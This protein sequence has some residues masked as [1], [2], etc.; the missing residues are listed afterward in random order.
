MV[1]KRIEYEISDCEGRINHI[2]D[3]I[4]GIREDTDIDEVDTIR[5]ISYWDG[6]LEVVKKQLSE[7][8]EKKKISD[9]FYSRHPEG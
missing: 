4:K 7:L 9:E 2:E 5:M 1:L 8:K 3:T 6:L